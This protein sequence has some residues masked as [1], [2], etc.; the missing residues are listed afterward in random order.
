MNMIQRFFREESGAT[1]VEYAILV[2]LLSI[3]TIAIL[4]VLAPLLR[5][6]FQAVVLALQTAGV[7]PA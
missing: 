1:M 6:A 3:A 2:A 7:V 5:G 4:V